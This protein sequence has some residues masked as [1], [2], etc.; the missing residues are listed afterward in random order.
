[1]KSKG[2]FQKLKQAKKEEADKKIKELFKKSETA[3]QKV[4]D[5]NV[6]KAR[7]LAMKHKI[8]LPKE[9]K[10]RFCKHCNTY[11]TSSNSRIRLAKGKVVYYC[12]ACK[13]YTRYPYQRENNLTTSK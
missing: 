12:R 8:R 6:R 7:R 3:I 1:M 2:Y 5:R 4:A 9:L 13:K 10:I 11:F